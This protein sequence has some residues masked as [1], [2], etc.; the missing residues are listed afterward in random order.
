MSEFSVNWDGKNFIVRVPY[1]DNWLAKDAPSRTWSKGIKAWILPHST[2]NVRHIQENFLSEYISD[3]AAAEL[4][5]KPKPKL[6]P[7]PTWYPFPE[8]TPP[9]KHQLA[10]LDHAWMK[11]GESW[12]HDPGLGKT[13]STIALSSAYVMNGDITAIL[14][15]CPTPIKYVWPE[16]FAQHAPTNVPYDFHVLVS[17]GTKDYRKWTRQL[18]DKVP[19]LIVGIEALS[20]G[21]AHELV[22]DYCNSHEH[23]FCAVDES[24]RIKNHKSIRTAKVTGIGQA[25]ARKLIL[26]GTPVT[27]GMEDLYA[28][29][30]FLDESILGMSSFFSYRNRYCRMGGFEGRKIIG[31]KNTPE[32][33]GILEPYAHVVRKNDV[34]DLPPKVYTRRSVP[35]SAEQK[36]V[37]DEL[38]DTFGTTLGDKELEVTTVLERMTRFQQIA[39]GFF[40]WKDEEGVQHIEPLLVNPKLDAMMEELDSMPNDA[41]VIIWARFRPELDAIATALRKKYGDLSTV[42]FHGG[43]SEDDRVDNV[44]RFQYDGG[45]DPLDPVRFMVSNQQVGGMGQTWTAASYTFYFSNTFSYEDRVQSEDR[46][47]G[48]L[49]AIDNHVTY[50]DFSVELAVEKTIQTA[51]GRKTSLAGF[52]SKKLQGELE[53]F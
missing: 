16:Q 8:A 27:Q 45:E 7:F 15:I 11:G 3:A 46:N 9:M 44:E 19:V 36:R 39:G 41:K 52:V 2:A 28:Q 21:K 12:F 18:D 42:E 5:D 48:R 30:N 51:L 13:Y 53:L 1:A 47:H 23:V 24:S 22:L 4:V 17:G 40:P 26:T 35:P 43:I 31:Y 32:L 49:S 37:Y 29:F 10:A 50:V 34:L 6:V 20:Q 14:V 25:C 38:K 33:M